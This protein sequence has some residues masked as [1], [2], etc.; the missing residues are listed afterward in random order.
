MNENINKIQAVINTLE[1][2]EI[3]SK[4]DTMLKIIG[5]QNILVEVRDAL[6]ALN[7]PAE[8]PEEAAE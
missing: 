6:S 5:C 7:Q 1:Q 3:Q 4:R 2:L 8:E